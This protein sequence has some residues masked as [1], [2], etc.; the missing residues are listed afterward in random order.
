MFVLH[1]MFFKLACIALGL[2]PAITKK[3][4]APVSSLVSVRYWYILL[5]S[6]HLYSIYAQ[7]PLSFIIHS[8]WAAHF[9]RDTKEDTVPDNKELTEVG[10]D[11]QICSERDKH[12]RPINN[13]RKIA[14]TVPISLNYAP[15]LGVAEGVA[16]STD[17]DDSRQKAA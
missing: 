6:F 11:F 14:T 10:W 16:S 5:T 4:L 8:M 9:R 1:F 7:M 12:A 2:S 15:C 13:I 3:D 17:N